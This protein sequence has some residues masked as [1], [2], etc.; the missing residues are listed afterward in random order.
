MDNSFNSS[1]KYSIQMR[2]QE[3]G[4]DESF[5]KEIA[6]AK[7]GILEAY[8]I[9]SNF[10]VMFENYLELECEI[11]EIA[12]RGGMFLRLD[13]S[14][15]S[16]ESRK[17]IRRIIN[18]LSSCRAYLD[19]IKGKYSEIFG[20]TS[21]EYGLLEKEIHCQYDSSISYRL[22]ETLRNNL[23][24][25]DVP[26]ACTFNNIMVRDEG[27]RQNAS[28][29]TPEL[30]AE[31]F[32][33]NADVKQIVRS[34]IE[35]LKDKKIDLKV[36]YRKYVECICGVHIF[37]RNQ[38]SSHMPKWIGTLESAIEKIQELKSPY[39]MNSAFAQ[40]ICV[41]DSK[42]IESIPLVHHLSEMRSRLLEKNRN[43]DKISIQFATGQEVARITQ[44]EH[45]KAQK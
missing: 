34:D 36:H 24:H 3:A 13:A 32:L 15:L 20:K 35:G 25:S 37:S 42:V 26:I 16:S 33:Q 39:Q 27:G 38:L 45:L 5:Y 10:D 21:N 1:F 31:R 30:M 19:Q 14:E 9:E 2:G 12:V 44:G 7:K 22:M 41:S 43:I 18:L 29:V 11:V 28:A 23:Q 6:V 17:V 8:I 4:I 40:K